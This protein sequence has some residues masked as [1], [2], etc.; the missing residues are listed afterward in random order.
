MLDGPHDGSMTSADTP[1]TSRVTRI[2]DGAER[3]TREEVLERLLPVVYDELRV[4]AAAQLRGE[5]PDHSLQPTALVHEAYVRL[6]ADDRTP[7]KDRG[8]FFRAAAQA[9][10]RI[11]VEHARS[12]GRDKRGAGRKRVSLSAVGALSWNDPA[13]LLALDEALRRLE[14]RDPR[15]AEVVLLRYF[16]G[17]SV[18]ETAEALGC[19]ER[20]VNRDWI[21]ARVWLERALRPGDG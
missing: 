10:R 7:W 11:L 8:H 19:S 17:L 9:M 4:L 21:F 14:K 5:R 2:L 12:R 18:A 13:D 16:G 3:L 6:V 15:S 1:S 20:T